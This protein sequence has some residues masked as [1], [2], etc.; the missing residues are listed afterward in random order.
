MNELDKAL[1]ISLSGAEAEAAVARMNEQIAEWGMVLPAAPPFVCDFGLGD[2]GNVGE[3]ETWIANEVEPGYCGKFLFVLDG[4]TCPLHHHKTK[5][6][7][8]YITKG[9]VRMICDGKTFEM[10]RGDV[11]PVAPG[12]VHSFTGI[13]AAL[14]LEVSMPCIIDDN[15]FANPKI[16]IGGN[17]EG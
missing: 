2:F 6:E 1:A 8:F 16:P 4:Q 12:V 7:T 10:K 13:G 11:L 9:R 15:F 14:L 5:H 17:Y 3:I